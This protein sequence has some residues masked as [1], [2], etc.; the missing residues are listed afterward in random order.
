[1]DTES[2]SFLMYWEDLRSTGKEELVNLYAQS[3]SLETLKISEN[4]VLPHSFAIQEI[5]P[6]PFNP[7]TTILYSLPERSYVQFD[8]VNLRGEKVMDIF[9]GYASAGMNS[10]DWKPENIS[11]GMYFIRMQIK[12]ELIDKQQVL[13]IK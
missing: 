8:A 6:N 3:I 5:F 13:L 9:S 10:F 1:M 12:N 7:E 2:S 4:E 11:S